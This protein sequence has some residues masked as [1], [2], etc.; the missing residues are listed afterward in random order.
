M[1]Q[2]EVSVKLEPC[3]HCGKSDRLTLKPYMADDDGGEPFEWGFNVLCNAMGF[4]SDP[5]RGCG[6]SG[7]WG[8]SEADA[9]E[10]WNRRAALATPPVEAEPVA[11][12]WRLKDGARRWHLEPMNRD[13]KDIA[14]RGVEIELLFTHPA[15]AARMAPRDDAL[16]AI[17]QLRLYAHDPETF[18]VTLD[19]IAETLVAEAAA[20]LTSA[21]EEIAKLRA[22]LGFYSQ[23]WIGGHDRFW[24]PSFQLLQDCG[25]RARAAL[26]ASD[27]TNAGGE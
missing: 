12:R 1:T 20:A 13:R 7:A 17:D 23:Q 21:E 16:S 6:A 11:W 18:P 5:R 10:A 27:P 19:D 25:Q 14:G 8:E 26:Q 4:E 24:E 9:V 22:A 2:S 15:P 3:P